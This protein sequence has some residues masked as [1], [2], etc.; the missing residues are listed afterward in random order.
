[1]FLNSRL[2]QG[3]PRVKGRSGNL[4]AKLDQPQ[5]YL[6]FEVGKKLKD[7]FLLVDQFAEQR[8]Q[9]RLQSYSQQTHEQLFART[10]RAQI[11]G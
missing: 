8:N 10:V 2:S 9:L 7:G 6:L 3:Q 4:A 5:L 1:V 11:N